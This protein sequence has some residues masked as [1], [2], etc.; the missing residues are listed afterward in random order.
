M[1]IYLGSLQ[2]I[3]HSGAVIPV[4]VMLPN[5]IWM[6]LPKKAAAEPGKEPLWLT[7]VENIGRVA[8]L[9]IPFFYDL[10]FHR[11]LALP[12]AIGMSLALMLYYACWARYFAKGRKAELLSAPFLGIPLPLAVAPVALLLLSAYLMGSWWMLGAAL[13]FGAAHLWVSALML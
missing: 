8:I 6:T 5:V 10:D 11:P 9:V 12:V 3:L 1:N 2:F 7:I 13:L 4:L